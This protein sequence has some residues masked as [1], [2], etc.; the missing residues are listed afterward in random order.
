MSLWYGLN[1]YYLYLRATHSTAYQVVIGINTVLQK[2]H[3]ILA[4][5]LCSNIET[6]KFAFM[7]VNKTLPRLYMRVTQREGE[8]WQKHLTIV[9]SRAM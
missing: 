5:A 8:N 1:T 6:D 3:A 4:M 9:K 2:C 7:K